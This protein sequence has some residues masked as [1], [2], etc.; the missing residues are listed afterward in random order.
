PGNYHGDFEFGVECLLYVYS[1]KLLQPNKVFLVRGL[2]EV[3]VN[4]ETSRLRHQCVHKYGPT[5]GDT[6]F[7]LITSVFEHLPVAIVV[8]ESIVCV[9]SGI[10]SKCRLDKL[11]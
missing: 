1:L 10:P 4:R 11:L 6:V 9:H 7:G 3:I 8:D 2:N 5:T